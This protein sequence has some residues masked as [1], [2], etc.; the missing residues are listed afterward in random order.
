MCFHQGENV[1]RASHEPAVD[2]TGMKKVLIVDDSRFVAEEIRIM[3]EETEFAPVQHCTRG[4]EALDAYRETTPDVV[5]MDIVLPG[6]DGFETA[7]QLLEVYPDA[8]VVMISSLA[9][10]ETEKRAREIGVSGF[11]CKPFTAEVLL[12]A[13]RSATDPE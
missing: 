8:K 6:I 7:E 12:E 9:Y 1:R 13:L 2:G 10:E 3:L 4:E 5:C 11:I